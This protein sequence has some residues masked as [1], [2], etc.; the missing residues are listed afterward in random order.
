MR[1]FLF[2]LLFSLVL[3][4]CSPSTQS[5]TSSSASVLFDSTHDGSSYEKAIIIKAKS[6]QKGV[7]A[8]YEWLRNNYPGYKKITQSLKSNGNK[9]YDAIFIETKQ[10]EE[11]TI[12]FDITK[13]FGKGL[14]F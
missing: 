10:E 4:S 14:G 11:K 5:G 9:H 2:S 7:A 8:E 13:F 3:Y 1:V 6:E 12:Y